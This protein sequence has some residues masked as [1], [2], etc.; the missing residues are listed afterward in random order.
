[1]TAPIDPADL[2]VGAPVF[3]DAG[4]RVGSIR[5]VYPHYIAVEAVAGAPEAFRV[6]LG[7]VATIVDGVVALGIDL[8]ALDPMTS[9]RDTVLGLPRHGETAP[10]ADLEVTAEGTIEPEE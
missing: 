9:D 3:D 6:P 5:A 10:P 1:M 2:S 8:M 7:A 4:R